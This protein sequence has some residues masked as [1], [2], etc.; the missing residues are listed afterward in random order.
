MNF[1]TEHHIKCL[2]TSVATVLHIWTSCIWVAM[3]AYVTNSGKRLKPAMREKWM[4]NPTECKLREWNV[5]LFC[6]ILG[7]RQVIIISPERN[8]EKDMQMIISPFIT[9]G[10]LYGRLNFTTNSGNP[11]GDAAVSITKRNVQ[12]KSAIYW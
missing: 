6:S 9:S 7:D 4:L 8:H 3:D 1:V 5:T 12:F 11:H 2:I 10:S